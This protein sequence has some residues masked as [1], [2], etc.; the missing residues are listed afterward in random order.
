[1]PP[2]PRLS[3]LLLSLALPGLLACSE[4]QDGGS[5]PPVGADSG[6]GADAG[7]GGAADAAA[8]AGAGGSDAAADAGT[9]VDAGGLDAGMVDAGG[10]VPMG[11]IQTPDRTWTWVDF[12]QSRCMNGTPTGIGVNREPGSRKLVIFLMGG[13][14]CF[15][16]A[17]CFITANTDGY[18]AAKFA[19]E[20]GLLERGPFSRTATVNPLRDW[21]YVY[22]PY[23]TGDVHA[24]TNPDGN[25]QGA[26]YNFNGY[27]NVGHYLERLVPTFADVEEVLLTGV[28]AGGFGAMFNF[29]QVQQAFGANVRVTLIDDS[30]PPMG[31]DYIPACLQ[32]HFRRTW[33][34]ADG[35]LAECTGCSTQDGSFIEPYVD[36][37]MDR[38]SDRNFGVISSDADETIRT[39]WGFGNNDCANLF[40]LGLPAYAAERFRAGLIDARDRMFGGRDNVRLYMPQ[41]SRHVWLSS[42]PWEVVHY[43]VTLS[44]WM[45]QALDDDPSWSHVPTP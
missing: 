16:T 2:P 17:T 21:S 22:V 31:T 3:T 34:L 15:N 37:V 43:G 13:N 4:N 27:R 10:P 45:Q 6:S 42:N 40:A 19:N 5:A 24:G 20:V 28:S 11:P 35:P 18:G 1:M 44:D 29:D 12:P 8:D 23:C 38:Y 30:G 25:V 26:R 39:F 32:N 7:G 33:G 41:S 14:A 9:P 36:Y